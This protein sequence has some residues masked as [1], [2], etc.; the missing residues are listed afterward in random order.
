MV[1]S[2]IA[3]TLHWNFKEP[4]SPGGMIEMDA[5][6]ISGLVKTQIIINTLVNVE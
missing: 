6:G 1:Y 2:T 4:N 3:T 5:S